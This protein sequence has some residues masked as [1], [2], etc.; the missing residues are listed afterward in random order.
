MKKFK[1]GLVCF[2]LAVTLVFSLTS[3]ISISADDEMAMSKI[4]DALKEKLESSE[5]VQIFV[6]LKDSIKKEDVQAQVF[7][8]LK[9]GEKEQ[10]LILGEIEDGTVDDDLLNSYIER[11][12][13]VYSELYMKNNSELVDKYFKDEKILFMSVLTP[14][15]VLEVESSK[16]EEIA[17]YEEV[18]FLDMYVWEPEEPHSHGEASLSATETQLSTEVDLLSTQATRTG[19]NLIQSDAVNDTYGYTGTGVKIGMVEGGVPNYSVSNIVV[20]NGTVDTSSLT[21]H[22]TYVANIINNVAP[23]AQ[24]YAASTV[25]NYTSSSI[26]AGTSGYIAAIEWLITTH[27]VNII[28]SSYIHSGIRGIYDSYCLWAE[29]IAINHSVHFVQATG[30]YRV[31][32]PG[33]AYNVITVG[34]L[35]FDPSVDYGLLNINDFSGYSNLASEDGV[36][37]AFKPDITAPGTG[38][39]YDGIENSGPCAATAHVSGAV[40]LMCEQ[41]NTLKVQQRAV[42][43]ILAATPNSQLPHYYTPEEWNPSITNNYSHY[44]AGV[45]NCKNAYTTIRYSRYYN[46]SFTPAQ[47]S[48][49]T[50]QSYNISVT[51]GMTHIRVAL[52]WLHT[53]TGYSH[54]MPDVYYEGDES[55]EMQPNMIDLEL[56]V[57]Y[58]NQLVDYSVCSKGNI[59]IIDFDPRDYGTGTYTI[60]VYP[61]SSSSQTTT[62]Y[63][64]AW[65]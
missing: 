29:H 3:G 49:G 54:Y 20:R 25:A 33:M 5:T 52:A 26:P 1:K 35:E 22:A 44:G 9:I 64:V 21:S 61:Y 48:A 50:T 11:K 23:D 42:K 47:V 59:E 63:T 58:G 53:A 7:E 2:I 43:A 55:D 17:Q 41:K 56:E 14:M 46:G 27:N 31:Y 18:T 40:A 38:T 51:S 16:V 32:P 37:V 12:N 19:L 39:V 36:N 10:K 28:N 6:W 34:D 24:I 62:Y 57:Y 60:K 15:A 8:E 13:D 45:L 4:S 30:I 65:W